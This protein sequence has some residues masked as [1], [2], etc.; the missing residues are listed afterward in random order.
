MYE[1]IYNTLNKYLNKDD[2]IFCF[3]N[4]TVFYKLLDRKPFYS[5]YYNLYWDIC[6]ENQAYEIDQSLSTLNI[7]QLPPAIVYFQNSEQNII[8]HESIFRGGNKRNAQ[9]KIDILLKKQ[10]ANGAYTKVLQY[11]SNKYFKHVN[12]ELSNTIDAIFY[13]YKKLLLLQ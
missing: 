11:D 3:I 7:E 8:F 5:D 1:E 4:N 6:P 2:R 13:D 9:R 10:I 12:K